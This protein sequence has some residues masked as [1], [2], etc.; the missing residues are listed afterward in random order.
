MR[1]W[2][3]HL[4]WGP[5]SRRLH[6]SRAIRQNDELF[7]D[8]YCT[9]VHVMS[10]LMINPLTADLTLFMLPNP[11]RTPLCPAVEGMVSGGN[12]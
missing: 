5:R 12:K 1:A 7:A 10:C 8:E 6:G 11:S 2:L 3:E 9:C 4:Q